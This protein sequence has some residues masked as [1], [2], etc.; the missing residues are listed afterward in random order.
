LFD[1]VSWI[2][3]RWKE[4]VYGVDSF[5][6]GKDLEARSVHKSDTASTVSETA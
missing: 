3:Y 6:E 1:M 4:I 2:R 5:W